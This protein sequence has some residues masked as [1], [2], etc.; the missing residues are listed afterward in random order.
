MRPHLLVAI[1]GA[2]ALLLPGAT[3]G[4][5]IKARIETVETTLGDESLSPHQRLRHQV[6]KRTLEKELSAN[7][8]RDGGG[9]GG[10]KGGGGKQR[11]RGRGRGRKDHGDWHPR[12]PEMCRDSGDDCCANEPEGEPAACADGYMPNTQPYS[13]DSCPNYSC[14]QTW[15]AADDGA[16]HD[17]CM[18]DLPPMLYATSTAVK[19]SGEKSRLAPPAL[20]SAAALLAAWL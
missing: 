15:Q 1:V 3:R 7:D 2:A 17:E 12:N 6:M 20:L 5:E 13:Y 11:A 4:A 19:M 14:C 16:A 9:G 8:D 18:N 10:T